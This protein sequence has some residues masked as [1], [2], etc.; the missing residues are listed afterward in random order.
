M[1]KQSMIDVAYAI[2]KEG[3]KVFTFKELYD[4]VA[5]VLEMDDETKMRNIGI[6]YTQL[7]V[8]GRFVAL[9]DNTWDSRERHTYEKSHDE[10]INEV[11]NEVEDDSGA[12]EE[13]KLE[14]KEYNAEIE[15]KEIIDTDEEEDEDSSSETEEDGVAKY[16]DEDV[17]TLIGK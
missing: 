11:Y 2:V 8:D 1:E 9:G 14:E 15:G 16:S 4:Q 6:F 3:E 7:T 5:L 13:D 12:D 10:S 17:S